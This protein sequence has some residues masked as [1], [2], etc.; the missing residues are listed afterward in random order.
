MRRVHLPEVRIKALCGLA[1]TCITSGLYTVAIQQYQAALKVCAKEN[2]QQLKR[3]LADIH[4]GLADV[5]RQIG[6]PLRT[7]RVWMV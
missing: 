2:L 4:Y 5:Y 6:C 3:D 7:E 1:L